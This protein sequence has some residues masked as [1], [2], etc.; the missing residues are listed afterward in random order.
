MRLFAALVSPHGRCGR[1]EFLFVELVRAALLGLCYALFQAGWPL[2]AAVLIW[3]A[4]WPGI[5]GTIKRFRD[6]GHDPV[7]ILPVLTYLTVGFAAGWVYRQ[8]AL[9]LIT[10]GIY[11][12]YVLG[13]GGVAQRDGA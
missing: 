13:A 9:G 7:W 6:L 1:A 8:P 5:V 3:P 11:L 4:L 2:A 12:A 10:L